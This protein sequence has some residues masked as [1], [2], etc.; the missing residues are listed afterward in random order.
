MQRNQLFTCDKS[1]EINSNAT[2]LIEMNVMC[3][4]D[5]VI[6]VCRACVTE[7]A[8][9]TNW[10]P[11]PVAGLYIKWVN[12]GII[13]EYTQLITVYSFIGQIFSLLEPPLYRSTGSLLRSLYNLIS[14]RNIYWILHS[15][16][17]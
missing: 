8:L 7:F 14:I 6:C 5:F 4:I 12:T 2:L 17:F 1:T 10:F 9:Q 13:H 11:S 16:A 3:E 15:F